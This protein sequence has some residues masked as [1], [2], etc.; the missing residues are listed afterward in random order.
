MFTSSK[1]IVI[2]GFAAIPKNKTL[3]IEAGTNVYF[4]DNSGLIVDDKATLKVK[5]TRSKKVVFEGDRLEHSFSDIPGQWGTIWMRAGSI[6]NEI[7][8]AI[9]RNGIIGILVDSSENTARPTLK[10]ENT[11]I[12][13]HASFGI[14]GRETNI[15]GHNLVIGNAGQASL[16]A[17]IGGSYNFTHATFSNFWSNSLRQL[18]AVLINNFFDV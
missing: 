6:N 5:G 13:N 2:Y 16:A 1:P 14:L 4:H 17:T 18:P 15:E 9:I 12:Y 11:E 8:H 7:H 10:L 3:S